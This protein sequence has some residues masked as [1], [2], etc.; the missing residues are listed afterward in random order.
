M[1]E[2]ILFGLLLGMMHGAAQ[3]QTQPMFTTGTTTSRTDGTKVINET[4]VIETFST[5][6]GYTMSGT[7]ITFEGEPG[8]ETDYS[9]LIPGAATQFS[10][11][12]IVPGLVERTTVNRVTELTTVTTTTSVFQ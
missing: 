5:A 11:T 10:E 7:N 12:I 9:Q 6:E 1:K 8:P 3:A 4:L 2:A